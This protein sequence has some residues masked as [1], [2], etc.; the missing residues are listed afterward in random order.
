MQWC[1]VRTNAITCADSKRNEYLP[2]KVRHKKARQSIIQ[3]LRNTSKDMSD[4]V[5]KLTEKKV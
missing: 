5:I 1:G 3:M 4:M 2:L